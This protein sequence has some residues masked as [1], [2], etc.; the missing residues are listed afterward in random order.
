MHRSMS[1]LRRSAAAKCCIEVM[2]T[3]YESSPT[4]ELTWALI[5]ASARNVP[6][7]A[8]SVRSGGWQRTVGDG[9]QGKVLGVL[10]LGNIGSQVARIAG[11][12]GMEIS[13]S[14][15]ARAGWSAAPSSP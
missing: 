13:S 1:R 4:I 12:F 14:A 7:E 9:I 2:H 11:A 5:L 6:I 15:P 8:A 10:G 3:K